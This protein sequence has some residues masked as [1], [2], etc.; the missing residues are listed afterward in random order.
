MGCLKL[1]RNTLLRIAHTSNSERSGEDKYCAGTYKYKY[2]GQERQDELGLNWDSFKYRNYDYAIGRFM[3]IDPLSEDYTYNSTYAFQE[4]KMGMGIELEGLE[5]YNNR[6][7][8]NR[9]NDYSAIQGI[10][11]T[12]IGMFSS[13]RE[14]RGAAFNTVASNM[15]GIKAIEVLSKHTAGESLSTS[16]VIAGV[17]DFINFSAIIVGAVEGGG[18]AKSAVASEAGEVSSA[19]AKSESGLIY[20][21]SGEATD[22]GKPYIGRTKQESPA[23]RGKGAMDGRDR[24]NAQVIDKYNPNKPKEGSYKEQKAIN[25]NGGVKNL[26]NKRNEMS[27]KN[28]KAY[29]KE[30]KKGG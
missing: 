23:V 11:N 6:G 16:E 1:E 17:A 8:E 7:Q 22:S 14:V 24:T 15:P 13:D 26:D 12:V 29:E 18:T 21:V 20:K 3:S 4:N 9:T 28:Y 5:L 30:N 2:Q 27:E 25:S 19:G 10:T